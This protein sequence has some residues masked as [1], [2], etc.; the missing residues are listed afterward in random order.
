MRMHSR[1]TPR[2][3]AT[4]LLAGVVVLAGCGDDDDHRVRYRRDPYYDGR[5][6]YHDKYG[7]E[8]GYDEGYARARGYPPRPVRRYGEDEDDYE[9]RL[10][11]WEDE[12]EDLYDD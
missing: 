12:M 1:W 3:L 10:E 6:G 7:Y 5:H 2:I 8:D 11:D 4:L 9:D